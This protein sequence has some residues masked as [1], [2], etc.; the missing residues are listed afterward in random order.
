MN[1]LQLYIQIPEPSQNRHQHT[2]LTK[3]KSMQRVRLFL[4]HNIQSHKKRKLSGQQD[5]CRKNFLDKVGKLC[6]FSNPRQ[7]RI[8]GGFARFWIIQLHFLD[9]LDTFQ[10]VWKLSRSYRHSFRSSK[11]SLDYPDTFPNY[12]DTFRIVRKLS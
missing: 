2:F 7:M 9:D 1:V 8:K 4:N 10:I 12:P 5:F 11:L 6:Q 3:A